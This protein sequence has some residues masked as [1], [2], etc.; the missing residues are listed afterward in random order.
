[1]KRRLFLF[2]FVAALLLVLGTIAAACGDGEE[3]GITVEDLTG[4]WERREGGTLIQFNEDGTF[5]AAVDG[6]R[7][8]DNPIDLAEFR[9]EGTLLTFITSEG[10]ICPSAQGVRTTAY[11]VELTEEGDLRFVLQGDDP[12]AERTR[13]LGFG[14]WRRTS[15]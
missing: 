1:M 7:L 2:L 14:P 9:L 6:A 4:I 5:R 15:P 12:C 13:D 8:E 11:Q 10:S 3:E